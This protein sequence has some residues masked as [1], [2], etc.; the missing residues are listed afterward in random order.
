MIE[1]TLYYN[2][3][4][5]QLE[6]TL[7]KESDL[8]IILPNFQPFLS[9]FISDK[10]VSC[11]VYFSLVDL[12]FDR[13]NST[14]LSDISIIWGDRFTFHETEDF[15]WTLIQYGSD[16]SKYWKMRSSKDFKLNTIYC[17]NIGDKKNNFIS[18]YCMVAFAQSALLHKCILIHASV[19]TNDKFGYA[20]L[21]KSG[22]GKSTHSRLWL[23]YLQGFNLLN[24]DNPAI[25]V[26]NDS[27]LIYG[28]P[29]SGKTPCYIND[30]RP[31]KGL[32]RLKQAPYNL[33][34]IRKNKDALLALLPSCSAIRWNKNLYSTLVNILIDIINLTTIAELQCL[35]NESAAKLCF[36]ELNKE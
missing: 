9:D 32:V 31:L 2:I 18:W 27:I 25:R 23:A 26:T 12:D 1:K 20:F 36:N 33:F 15:Y 29:W 19:V 24:D 21:G 22:T 34:E 5:L 28:T 4:D 14:L 16:P 30:V 6:I 7:P 8:S 17:G 3:A 13:E 10:P 35:P 11:R